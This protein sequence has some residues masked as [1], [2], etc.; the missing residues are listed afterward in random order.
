MTI[1]SREQFPV[2]PRGDLMCQTELT[3]SA[4]TSTH[5]PCPANR[6]SGRNYQ[7]ERINVFVPPVYRH[8]L[9]ALR[10]EWHTS[11]AE[12]VRRVLDLG[13]RGFMQTDSASEGTLHWL[14]EPLGNVQAAHLSAQE[15]A[16]GEGRSK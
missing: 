12:A 9:D 6:V 10:A 5:A 7:R 14:D 16:H 8:Q 11:L 3:K 1:I 4:E 2:L 13:L 15:P